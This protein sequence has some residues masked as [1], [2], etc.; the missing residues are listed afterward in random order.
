IDLDEIAKFREAFN[1]RYPDIKVEAFEASG[2]KVFEKLMTEIDADRVA[3]DVFSVADVVPLMI[4][5]EKNEL[6]KY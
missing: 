3:G 1:K 2:Y 4:L 6:L 5:K